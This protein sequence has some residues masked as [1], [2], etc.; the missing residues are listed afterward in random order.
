MKKTL[1]CIL[2]CSWT[3]L[4]GAQ[5]PLD[6]IKITG[7][8]IHYLSIQDTIFLNFSPYQEKIF[9]HHIAP[10]QTLYSISKFYGLTLE[11]LYFY[12]PELKDQSISIGQPIRIPIPNKSI[13]RYKI[14][15]FDAQKNVP[16]CYRIKKGDTM[17]NISKRIFQMPIDTVMTR[18]QLTSF[19]LTI[20]QVL[21][22][23]WMSIEGI[24]ETNR[25]FRGHPIWKKNEVMRRKYD[26]NRQVKKEYQQRG[27]AY[28]QKDSEAKEEEMFAL[29][30]NAPIN[31]IL[32]VTNPM[33]K[34]TV[35]VRVIGRIPGTVY[36]DNVITVLSPAAAKMLGAKDSRFYVKV[37]YTK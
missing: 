7:D 36:G 20:G 4:L 8:S 9:Q 15:G 30:R 14:P 26:N 2:L 13:V 18:N 27:V 32:A 25:K 35:F 22:L 23:G 12:N 29:H 10:K 34:R 33:K 31:S 6:T 16:V 28:W 5:A 24:P 21:Q 11:E 1:F 37:R 3:L 19:E 17:Y